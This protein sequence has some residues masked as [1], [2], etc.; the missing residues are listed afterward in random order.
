MQTRVE[1][2]S[3]GPVEVPVEAY[4]GASTRR[5][6]ENF[7]VSGI[8]MPLDIIHALAMI[9]KHAA[10]VNLELGLL[11][12]RLADAV[13]S[14]ARE[15]QDGKLD[16]QFVVDVFQT[17]SGTSSNMNVNEVIAARANEMLAGVRGSKSPVHPN[18]HVNLGQSSNDAIPSAIHIASLCA[19]RN[20]LLPSLMD[21]KT[22]LEKKAEEFSGILKIG[23]THLQDAV[24]MTLGD[25]FGGYARQ[26]ELGAARIR[27]VEPR[28]AELALGGTA[29]G[30]GVNT[31]PDFARMV[32]GRIREET[33]APFR[34]AANHFEAQAARD[35]AVETSGA[36]K[37]LAVGLVKIANDLRWLSCGPRAGFSEIVLPALQPGSS[38]MPGKVNPIIPESVLQVAAQVMGNDLTITYGASSGNFELNVMMPVI[39]YNLLQSTALLSRVCR[40]FATKCIA[41]IKADQ[42]RCAENVEKSLAMAT[43]LVPEIGYDS[44]AALAKEAYETGETIREIVLRKGLLSPEKLD[45]LL[46][47][48]RT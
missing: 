15:V 42:A 30:T 12:A 40:L 6:M 36:L 47:K 27:A 14:A 18:D 37:T 43:F 7:P 9:K 20:D 23:R 5:A 35:A 28:S 45:A 32:I 44:A 33:G 4:Y 17:G 48:A 41:G 39:G 3:L 34:E 10:G 46:E 24:P 8:V 25:E 16:P 21:L 31:H 13:H 11:D 2:D 19:I 38:I 22:A 26:M 1:K 29:V